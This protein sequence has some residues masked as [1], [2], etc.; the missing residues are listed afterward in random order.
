MDENISSQK[1][2]EMRVNC[3]SHHL[4]LRKQDFGSVRRRGAAGSCR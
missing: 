3:I 2:R 4:A 1:G